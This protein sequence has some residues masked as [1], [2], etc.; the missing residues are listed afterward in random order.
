[1]DSEHKLRKQNEKHTAVETTAR[2]K[3]GSLERGQDPPGSCQE[4]FETVAW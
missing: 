3:E 2:A 4:A 1:M